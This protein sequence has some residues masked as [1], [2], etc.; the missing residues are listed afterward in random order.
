MW[1]PLAPGEGRD[2]RL[3]P[4]GGWYDPASRAAY[5]YYAIIRTLP[6]GGPFGFK[7]EGMGLA[8]ADSTAG[9][10]L[11]FKR[12]ATSLTVG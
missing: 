1:F 3:W 5:L 9:Q 11:E 4:F 12:V 2:I 10:K 7:M 8:R 6:P